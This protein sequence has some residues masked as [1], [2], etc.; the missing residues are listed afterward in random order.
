[1]KAIPSFR[2]VEHAIWYI[3]KHN[4]DANVQK[5]KRTGEYD[6]IPWLNERAPVSKVMEN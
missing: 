4:L 2:F 6:I 3:R 5:N 1:M